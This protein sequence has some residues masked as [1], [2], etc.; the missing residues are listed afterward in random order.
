MDRVLCLIL[1]AVVVVVSVLALTYC[2][3][4]IEP[5]I[6]GTEPSIAET[7]PPTV[8]T[9]EDNTPE[10]TEDTVETTVATEPPTEGTEPVKTYYEV[11]LS[12]ELQD[13]V[14]S[15][16]AERDIDPA[17]VI[18]MIWKESRFNASAVGDSGNSLGLMQIQP[19]WHSGLMEQLGCNDLHDPF[20]NVTVGIHI[21]A[22]HIG[23]YDGDIGMALTS[24]NAG[25]TGAYNNYFSKGIYASKYAESIMAYADEIR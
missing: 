16:C 11:P 12:E 19:R 1:C 20:Q 13:Y 24:Y 4:P 2:I 8:G 3:A 14:I 21:L 22:S 25:A 18:A 9:T 10:T 17:I 15:L 6:T 7:V 23:R 5:P